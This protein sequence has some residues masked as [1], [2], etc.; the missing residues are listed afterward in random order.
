MSKESLKANWIMPR[1]VGESNGR[2]KMCKI[3]LSDAEYAGK[4]KKTRREVFPTRWNWCDVKGVAGPANS[5]PLRVWMRAN[6]HP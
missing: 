1:I 5:G 4:R 3:S 2:S 6:L